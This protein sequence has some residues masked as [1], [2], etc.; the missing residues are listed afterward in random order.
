MPSPSSSDLSSGP[1]IQCSSQP[2]TPGDLRNA[3]SSVI[4]EE[5]NMA[6]FSS[7]QLQ[8]RKEQ[9]ITSIRDILHS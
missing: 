9:D 3:V 4:S 1:S 5:N 8:S 6:E 7:D 2:T